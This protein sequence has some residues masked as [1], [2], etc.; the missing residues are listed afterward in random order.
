MVPNE[1][2]YEDTPSV[3]VHVLALPEYSS[4]KLSAG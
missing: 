1:E 2:S 4:S 3:R